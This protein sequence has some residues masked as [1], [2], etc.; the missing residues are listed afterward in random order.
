MCVH[1]FKHVITLKCFQ[2]IASQTELHK[3]DKD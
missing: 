3:K 2:E 1:I